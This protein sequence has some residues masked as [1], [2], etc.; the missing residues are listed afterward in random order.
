MVDKIK[1]HFP[2]ILELFFIT[3]FVTVPKIRWLFEHDVPAFFL[4]NFTENSYS[5]ARNKIH[6]GIIW[7]TS[8]FQARDP[9]LIG[10][11]SYDGQGA[12]AE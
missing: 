8:V 5:P 6:P 9:I 7:V 12:G 1:L 10:G 11:E 4:E 3:V 2:S